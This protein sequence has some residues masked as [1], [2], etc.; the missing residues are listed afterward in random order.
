[1]QGGDL[2]L[3]TEEP[4]VV[5]IDPA[6][7]NDSTV[8][9]IMTMIGKP[10]VCL[11]A[12]WRGDDWRTQSQDIESILSNYS[13]IFTVNI[14]TLHGEGISDYLSDRI[15]VARLP[16]ERMV[17]SFMWQELRK[18][19]VNKSFTYPAVDKVER[20]RFEDQLTSLGAKWVGN[21]FKVN[22]PNQR[23]KHDDYGDSLALTWF[24]L[25]NRPQESMD[26]NQAMRP[27]VPRRIN[28][29]RLSRPKGFTR[30]RM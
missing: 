12:E 8:M 6:R 20:Y 30:P 27:I 13:N 11:W 16:M 17:Q 14:D 22:S 4:V 25:C 24:A 26:S 21:L 29:P 2:I 19:I 15:P 10:H 5:G 1:L 9:T 23:N 7:V 28:R 18:A 3:K